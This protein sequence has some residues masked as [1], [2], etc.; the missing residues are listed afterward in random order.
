M[1]SI[2]TLTSPLHDAERID[3]LT[4][5][6]LNSLHIQYTFRGPDFSAYGKE[7]LDLIY[8]RTGG[9]EGTPRSSICHRSFL[10]TT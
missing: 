3:M 10:S 2:Y 6:F 5:D 1:I 4:Q 9:T 7:G 8:V